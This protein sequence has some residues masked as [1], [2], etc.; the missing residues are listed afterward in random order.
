MHARFV[1]LQQ[2]WWGLRQWGWQWSE[3]ASLIRKTL[4]NLSL[5]VALVI[6]LSA[7]S[8]YVFVFGQAEQQVQEQL[9]KYVIERGK[10]EAAVFQL[11]VDRHQILKQALLSSPAITPKLK[12]YQWRDGTQRNFPEHKPLSEFDGMQHS[13]I[14]LGRNQTLTPALS[15]KL[16]QFEQLTRQY[17]AAWR[18]RAINTYLIAPEN[19]AVVYWPEVPGPLMVPGDFDV[20]DEVF[21]YLSDRAHDPMRQTLWTNVYHDPASPDWIVSV[22][23]PVDDVAGNQIATIG[24]DIILTDLVQRT[25]QDR[26]TGTYNLIFSDDGHLIV[27]PEFGEAIQAKDGKLTIQDVNQPH[28]NRIFQQVIAQSPSLGEAEARVINHAIEGE[29]LAV[30]RLAGPNWNFVTVYPQTLLQPEALTAAKFILGSGLTSLL[31]EVVLIY[32]GLREQVAIPL[33]ELQQLSL[34]DGLTQVGNR[35]KFDHYLEQEWKRLQRQKEESL[36]LILCDV[37]Y[38][39]LYND[40]YG[41]Q[42]GDLCLQEVAQVLRQV[43]KRPSDLVARYGGEEFAVILPMTDQAGAIVIAHHIQQAIHQ[44]QLPHAAS[45]V[46]QIVTVSMG[47][48]TLSPDLAMPLEQLIATAD[49]ALYQAKQQGRDRFCYMPMEQTIPLSAKIS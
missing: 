44:L 11:A 24:H 47:I 7:I 20:H 18:D 13:S 36:S 19:A 14:F 40:H 1:W 23:T 8:S 12:L 39:K 3:P 17:G 26:L 33:E 41:H 38:F 4:L 9:S 34:L 43:L 6:V 29:F 42:A 45:P 22:V 2:Y 37:D 25:L 16:T 28:L 21:F 30:T 5:R 10:R 48:C 49:K 15:Q 35:R 31:V 46:G 27:H 32:R